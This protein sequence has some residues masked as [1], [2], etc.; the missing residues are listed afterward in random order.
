MI[1][2]MVLI[3]ILAMGIPALAANEITVEQIVE[4]F[5]TTYG[6]EQSAV[7]EYKDNTITITY[8][9]EGSDQTIVANLMVNGNIIS[10]SIDNKD[11]NSLLITLLIMEFIDAAQQLQG[12]QPGEIIDVLNSKE[13]AN[14]TLEK[15]GIEAKENGNKVE[16]K[17]DIQKKIPLLDTTNMY[18]EVSDLEKFKEFIQGDGSTQIKRGNVGLSKRGA[19]NEAKITVGEKT[20]LTE[21]AYKSILSTLEVMFDSKDAADYFK[22]NYSGF[23]VGNKEF[24][25]IKIEVEPVRDNME[26]VIFNTEYK[27]ARLTIDRQKVRIAI[28][29]EKPVE[30]GNKTDNTVAP[31]TELPKAGVN[32]IVFSTLLIVILIGVIAYTKYYNAKDVK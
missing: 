8:S 27:I 9:K 10:I 20:E 22:T 19:D 21:N 24:E 26:S 7:A 16:V 30:Q 1:V 13:A 18:I 29:Q 28:G 15:E 2:G 6:K 11:E 5:N 12:Y 4:K 17:F 31:K 23:N 3:L 14:Y 32:T 25:G